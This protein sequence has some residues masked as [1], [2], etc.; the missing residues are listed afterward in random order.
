MM[1]KGFAA[2]GRIVSHLSCPEFYA[3]PGN[4]TLSQ[5]KIACGISQGNVKE[6]KDRSYAEL[7]LRLTVSNPQGWSSILM[8]MKL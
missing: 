4:W 3:I 1:Q 2:S 6:W 5:L 8:L 7:Q